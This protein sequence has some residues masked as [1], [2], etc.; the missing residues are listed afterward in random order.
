[1]AIPV[2]E[3]MAAGVPVVVS[4]PLLG[5]EA[6]LSQDVGIVVENNPQAFANAIGRLLADR[7]LYERLKRKGLEKFSELEGSKMELREA[8]LYERI[9]GGR[10]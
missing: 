2:I 8:K 1:V 9:L 5:S 6:E 3:A 7:K 10:V 4:K